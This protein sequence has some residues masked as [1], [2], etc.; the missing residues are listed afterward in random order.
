MN[1]ISIKTYEILWEN[2]I[3]DNRN[4][5]AI[6]IPHLENVF[7]IEKKLRGKF[8]IGYNKNDILEELSILY[9]DLNDIVFNAQPWK[10]L[11]RAKIYTLLEII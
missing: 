10:D 6:H 11:K 2:G 9:I 8:F 7:I 4:K 5:L 1:I 3:W